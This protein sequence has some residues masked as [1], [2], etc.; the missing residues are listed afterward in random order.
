MST[1]LVHPLPWHS[2]SLRLLLLTL[3]MLATL[4]AAAT[5]I[6]WTWRAEPG[7]RTLADGEDLSALLAE[8]PWQTETADRPALPLYSLSLAIPSGERVASVR[9][10]DVLSDRVALDEALPAFAGSVNE[11]GQRR[12]LAAPGE[13]GSFPADF[14]HLYSTFRY[15]GFATAEIALAPLRYELTA[16][17]PVLYRL[18]AAR[19]VVET[20]PDPTALIPLRQRSEDLARGRDFQE[21]RVAN[22]AAA[23]AFAPQSAVRRDEGVFA[24]RSLPSI[25]GSGVDMVIV[26]SPEHTAT[27][28]TLA[29]FKLSLGLPTVV[30]DTDWI[31]ANYPQG[32][33][34]QETI[35]FFL[36]DALA[37]WGIRFVLLAGDTDDLPVRRIYSYFKDPPEE[38]PA[39]LYFADLDGS[40]NAD[41][42]SHFGESTYGGTQGDGV[43][44]I[45]DVNLG[46]VPVRSAA[47]A[48]LMVDKIIAYSSAPDPTYTTNMSFFAEVLF[49][50]TWQI[51]DPVEL[52]TRNG[53]DYA[54]S[55]NNDYVTP[56]MDVVR[57]YETDWLYP[58]SLPE[59]PAATLNDLNTRAHVVLHVGHGFRYTMSMGTGSVVANDMLAL[60]NGL[61]RLAC[62]YALNCT[63]CAIDY[64]CLGE[65]VL[66]APLGGG[67]V[68]IGTMREAFP[69][70]SVY[71]QNSFFGYLYGDSLSV[72]ECFTKSHND[73]ALLGSVEGSHRWTQMSYLLIGDPS[74][75]VWLKTPETL[76]TALVEPYTLTSDTLKLQVSRDGSPLTGARVIATKAGEHR[77]EAL[78]DAAGL[79]QIPFRA[80]SLG[81]IAISTLHRNDLPSFGQVAVTAGS[82]PRLA[83]ELLSV[84]DDPN[85]DAQLAGNA[86]GLLDAGETVRLSLRVHNSGTAAATA[87]SLDLSLPGGELSIL[88]GQETTGQSVPAGGQ[89]NLPA[90]FLLEAPQA[91]ADRSSLL[92]DIA[93]SYGGGTDADQL[94]LSTHAPVPG[95]FTFVIDDAAGNGDGQ[96]DAGETYILMP[97]WKNY[98]STPLAG[99]QASLAA[100]DPAGQVLSGPVALPVLG[101]LQRG[102]S[103]G[104]SLHETSVASPNRFQFT[105]SG[106]LGEAIVDTI[107][108]RRP[109]PPAGLELDSSQASTVID[110]A[111]LIPAPAPAAYLVYR[112]N[113]PGGPY[114]L[115]S[116]EPT[117]H[118]YF[119]NDQLAESTTYYFTV[120]SVDS[121]GFRSPP[122]GEFAWSTNPAMLDGWP[123]QTSFGTASSL[124]MGD[125][126]GD[127]DKEIAAGAE[128]LYAWHHDGVE[129][130]DGDNNSVTYGALS[131]VG[132]QFTAGLAMAD[133]DTLYPGLEIIGASR[134][135]NGI[136]VYHGDGTP[137]PGWPKSL[138]NWC[139]ATPAAADVDG[140]GEVEIFAMCI[141]GNLYAWNANGTPQIGTTGVFASGLGAWTRSSPSLANLDGDADLEI[142]IGSGGAKKLYA[143]NPN[144]S[145]VTGF[146]VSFNNEIHSSPSLGDLDGDYD[147]EIVFLC[148]NDSLYVINHNGTRYPGFP[149]YLAS[150]AA[151]LA[152]SPAL[153]DFEDDGQMEIVAGGVF[154]YTSMNLTVLNNQGQPLPGWPKHFEESSEA[155]PVV[156]D[157]D[158]DGELEILLGMETGYLYAFNED[159]SDVAGFPILTDAE[160]RSCPT[161]DDL[162]GDLDLDIGLYGWDAFVYV[163]DMSVFYK[164][165][166]PQWKMFRANPARTGL[167]TREEQ[168]TPSEE[169]PASAPE[170][171]LYANFPNPFNPNTKISFATPAGQGSVQVTLT[172]HDVQGRR[173][174]TLQDGMLPRGTMQN[175][176]WDGKTENGKPVASGIYFARVTMDD[177]VHARKMVLLK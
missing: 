51:G 177:T 96:P 168:I 129:I 19:V 56:Q 138:P 7:L 128:L 1:R 13:A 66:L 143:F 70:T 108:V 102:A 11:D 144:G 87:L 115:V 145:A 135:P 3:L 142:V 32:A 6:E 159:G 111:W 130:S 34:L 74:I 110:M 163:W 38:I 81:D 119:R 37:K 100:I 2:L 50:A 75:N 17:G 92:L 97:E 86:D 150:N 54:E 69:N 15:R 127:G 63:S 28:Q 154:A 118:A 95:L 58:G 137:A 136:Y 18:L 89:L 113:S 105:L 8:Q 151:G 126:D 156:I 82:G 61:D 149:V 171:R 166:L 80:E 49:P 157:L 68:V 158:G 101:L 103:A 106:P 78:S 62:I 120:E 134:A 152:P 173:L 42:D 107:T 139:W 91:L 146:P 76:A 22:R 164:N 25:E 35:R 39:E 29:D 161:A 55:V 47:D 26:C 172:I 167:F 165:G 123:L 170:G 98:G 27:F 104:I 16:A 131:P 4:P 45:A 67:I 169:L 59:S 9:L 147:M 93:L 174:A 83:L 71:Y 30:R 14:L 33:D 94:E 53:A 36:Q 40:W 175:A 41:G 57:L 77:A 109:T 148:E 21:R 116:S 23:A 90:V 112:G 73:W 65:A 153:V 24:P 160:L 46:R 12:A 43:D 162:D 99:W 52:I 125:I 84:V 176:V 114:T 124:V 31:R 121:S 79:V 5:Q 44:M 20:E 85:L 140:D 88:D 117:H 133:I 155:S 132:G 72:G 141:D 122:S 10:E 64:S 48:Q 60:T